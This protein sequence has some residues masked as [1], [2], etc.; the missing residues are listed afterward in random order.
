MIGNRA[1]YKAAADSEDW[2]LVI[3]VREI[4]PGNAEIFRLG[5]EDIVLMSKKLK[6]ASL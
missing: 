6:K 3:R 1:F 5:L 2:K 4:D